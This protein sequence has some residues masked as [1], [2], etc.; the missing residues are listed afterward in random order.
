M[1]GLFSGLFGGGGSNT[2]I[3]IPEGEAP[4]A[5]Q[6]VIP[7]KS[8]KD[9]AESMNR[10]EK[11][12]NRVLDQR[13]DMVGTGADIG[14]KQRGI[15]MQEAASYAS[16]LPKSESPDTSF[17]STPRPFDI[18][19]KGNTF[20]TAEGQSPK[21]AP[22]AAAPAKTLAKQAAELRHKD[23]KEYYLAAVQ[24]AK[25]TP[26]SY[27]PETVN[28]GFAQN[29]SDIYLPKAVPPSE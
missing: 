11:E 8:Y 29:K 15:E 23:A 18:T 7:Q 4:R 6:T 25:D 14:A 20:Q 27:M 16:S 24:K 1:S 2:Q 12:Y 21:A 13:Y 5:F 26:R 9:L 22:A 3:V 10:T 17:K 28:P 19:S